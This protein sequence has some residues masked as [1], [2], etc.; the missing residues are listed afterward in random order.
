[1]TIQ[2]LLKKASELPLVPG[3]YLMYNSKGIIIYIG[4]AVKLRNR[5]SQYFQQRA[6]RDYKTQK[7]I[8]NVDYFEV[9]ITRT[10]MEALILECTLI[11]QHK[12]KYNI[13]LKDDKAYPYVNLNTSLPYPRL[14]LAN[15]KEG[16]GEFYGPFG[17]RY[18]TNNLITTLMRTFKLPDCGRVFPRDIGKERP[19]LNFHLAACDGWC[20]A[21]MTEEQYSDRIAQVRQ[22]LK[23]Q[24]FS[25]AED[26]RKQMEAASDA[27]NFE[28][29]AELRDRRNAILALK[30]RQMISAG[31]ML[32]TDA[33]GIY[34]TE[35]RAC[36]CVLHYIGGVL[37]DKDFELLE[38]VCVEDFFSSVLRQYYLGREYLPKQIFI[39]EEIEDREL[40]QQALTE[41]RGSSVKIILPRRGEAVTLL[42]L[43]AK[44]AEEETERT[45]SAKDRGESSLRLLEDMTGL[46][47][48][49]RIEAYDISHTAGSD[50]VGGMIVYADGAFRRR[51][52]K[53]FRLQDME[54]QDDYAS[55][56]QVL[57]RRFRDFLDAKKGFETRPDLL[58]IDGGS[59]HA[60][61]AE[62]VLLSLNLEIPVFGMVKD[63]HHRTRALVDAGSKEINIAAN[64][65]VFA[66]IGS[67][68]EEV[69][70]VAIAYHRSLREK[71][72]SKSAL[73]D[74]PGIGKV[75]G[76]CLLKHFHSENAVKKASLEKLKDV[77]PA[78]AA[79]KVYKYYHEGDTSQ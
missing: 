59:M 18:L 42:E 11:K 39:P 62:E 25:L 66:L 20:R 70:R 51:D 10:E 79:E 48:L 27:L 34:R 58:L 40:L 15:R 5:V 43:A 46:S 35:G 76:E 52:Y 55:M 21:C 17:G 29:A 37:L 71:K 63:G 1:M 73:M 65:R 67:V 30:D 77:L 9:F 36:F 33:I 31:R 74:I 16:F 23:G 19:C 32:D 72:A 2:E 7:M 4:K 6:D 3:V 26:L 60:A 75:R 14:E 22:I 56:R 13:L 24:F 12:P 8:S 38:D 41:K 53:R 57:T 47:D 64:Q 68:Q 44:N 61:I 54:N 49:K 69:H 50:I 78:S 45:R 28:Q